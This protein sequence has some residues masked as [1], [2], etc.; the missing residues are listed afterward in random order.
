MRLWVD[1]GK[2]FDTLVLLTGF[3]WESPFPPHSKTKPQFALLLCIHQMI[4]ASFLDA[5]RESWPTIDNERLFKPI[6]FQI[7]LKFYYNAYQL[8]WDFS[9]SIIPLPRPL[10]LYILSP[11]GSYKLYPATQSRHLSTTKGT[12]TNLQS[13]IVDLFHFLEAVVFCLKLE[14]WEASLKAVTCSA[15]LTTANFICFTRTKYRP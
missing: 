11:R 14:G 13:G 3:F 2:S 15:H 7:K 8:Q 5:H 9:W 4:R 6:Y 10:H 12:Q 1:S